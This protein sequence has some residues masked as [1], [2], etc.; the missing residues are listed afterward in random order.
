MHSSV[1]DVLLGLRHVS[2]LQ[3]T[4]PSVK[5]TA[6]ATPQDEVVSPAA[7]IRLLGEALGQVVRVEIYELQECAPWP[8]DLGR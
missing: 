5:A 4:C 3:G 6:P 1:F 8:S 2:R 7:R